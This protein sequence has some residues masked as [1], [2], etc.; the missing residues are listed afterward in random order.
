MK[1][2]KVQNTHYLS[3]SYNS[4]I[5][6]KYFHYLLFL[7]DVSLILLQTIEVYHNQFISL[8][9]GGI[10]YISFITIIIK[11][12]D[13]LKKGIKFLIYIAIILIETGFTFI[14]N[15]FSL[16]KNNFWTII[17]NLTEIIFHR[18]SVLF[19]FYF[20]FS[21]SDYLLIVG[22][23]I[24]L[25]FLFLLI[26]CFNSNHLFTFFISLINLFNIIKLFI[27]E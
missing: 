18:I 9:D 4:L 5:V 8:K 26:Q 2:T 23:I 14:L 10:K 19:L 12:L 21:F 24:T 20:L 6:N 27:E 3:L 13:K 7:I 16:K 11:E 1:N 22:I 17:I 25:P 15:N